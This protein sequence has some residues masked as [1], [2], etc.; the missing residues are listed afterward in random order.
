MSNDP[1]NRVSSPWTVIRPIVRS[2]W[3]L[4][5]CKTYAGAPM[6]TRGYAKLLDFTM[7]SFSSHN[8]EAGKAKCSGDCA[9]AT[10]VTDGI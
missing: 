1:P 10:I 6:P 3:L 8:S 4:L 5:D 7:V 2:S 9:T